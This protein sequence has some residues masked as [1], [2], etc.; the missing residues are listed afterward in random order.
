MTIWRDAPDA[1]G[2]WWVRRDGQPDDVLRVT[3]LDEHAVWIG[4]TLCTSDMIR[5]WQWCRVVTPE[6][7]EALES[8]LRDVVD[9]YEMEDVDR[10]SA[11]YAVAVL[12]AVE[13]VTQGSPVA[14]ADAIR[15]LPG[16]GDTT[17]GGVS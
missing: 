5:G 9:A 15:A 2:M 6:R 4:G 17:D 11:R 13:E 3:R 16:D 8:A 10:P 1:S 7:V 12:R 14:V